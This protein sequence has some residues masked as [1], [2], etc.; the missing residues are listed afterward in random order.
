MFRAV[1]LLFL[2]LVGVIMAWLPN[3]VFEKDVINKYRTDQAMLN[4]DLTQ[5]S[6]GQ[7]LAI[8]TQEKSKRPIK[9]VRKGTTTSSITPISKNGTSLQSGKI[10]TGNAIESN[11]KVESF[12]TAS[13]T[14]NH[15]SQH[16]L[17]DLFEKTDVSSQF[18]DINN[19]E[20]TT[21]VSKKWC[22]HQHS[23]QLFLTTRWPYCRGKCDY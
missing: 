16:P 22:N 9:K 17:Y 14:V 20:S 18:Y 8:E 13:P 4:Q 19:Q 15:R 1:L 6:S 10:P 5:S 2:I 12:A 23:L 21:L 3:D 7:A 11:S